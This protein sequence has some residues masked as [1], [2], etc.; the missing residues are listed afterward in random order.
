MKIEGGKF[1]ITGGASMIGAHIA[2]QLLQAGVREVVLFDNYS[3]GSPDDISDLVHDPRVTLVRG[4]ILRTHELYDQLE[5][6]SGVFATAG[7]LTLPLSLNP[8]LGVAVNV[9]GMLNVYDACRYRNVEKVIFSSSIAAYGEPTADL[10]DEA[11]PWTW[12]NLQPGAALYA[13]SKIMG[14]S[15]GKLYHD[16]HGVKS[17][18]LR[19]SSVYGERQHLR[20]VNSVYIIDTYDRLR[21]GER[22][23]IPDD[24]SE[25]HDYI[26]VADVARANIMAMASDVSRESFNVA[27]GTAT[28][29]NRLVE[30]VQT[31]TGTDLQPEYKTPAGKIRAAVST[32]L[33]FSIEKIARMIGWK[34]EISFEDGIRRMVAW[35]NR[36][37][38][39]AARTMPAG[40]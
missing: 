18:S 32:K 26:H 2:E 28:S 20:A 35:R 40:T 34:P 22:P 14:E 7:F 36:E 21:R 9:Q 19:Y 13:A 11:T 37:P 23:I 3:L 29:L 39:K 33:D 30:I 4:D 6:T 24:G 17:I 1:L 10:I 38:H 12:S 16:R 27:T 31:I 8:H 15:F 5:E 25:V